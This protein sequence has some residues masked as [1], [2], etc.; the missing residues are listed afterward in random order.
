MGP[1]LTREELNKLPEEIRKKLESVLSLNTKNGRVLNFI[2]AKGGV[3]TTTIA[4]NVS[5]GLHELQKSTVLVDL[6][7]LF[8]EIPILLDIKPNF[9]WGEISKDISRLDSTYLMGVLTKHRSGIHVLPSPEKTNGYISSGVVEKLLAQTKELFDYTVVD[10]GRQLDDGIADV[11]KLADTIFVVTNLTIPCLVNVK[12]LLQ[13]I[14]TLGYS[15]DR[16]RIIVVQKAK[17]PIAI[18]T[19]ELTINKE[20]FWV[21]PENPEVVNNAIN[22]GEPILCSSD[23]SDIC[24]NIRE[25]VKKI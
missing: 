21:V 17:D 4:V 19:A 7:M 11:I 9:S 1:V 3:G 10:S 12:K 20:I 8:G 24:K 23:R 25:L 6:N 13:N 16:V 18:K 22:R 15:Q 5:L 14:H 2:G